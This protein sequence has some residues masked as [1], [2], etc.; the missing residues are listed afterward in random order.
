MCSQTNFRP[1]DSEA[2]DASRIPRL[3]ERLGIAAIESK[4]LAK[5]EARRKWSSSKNLNQC[6][7]LH[8][9]LW[10]NLFQDW[11]GGRDE[12]AER[13]EVLVKPC[14]EQSG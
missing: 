12:F 8:T 5:K 14:G 11:N 4:E 3:D 10:R 2:L 9:E 6:T 7:G 1:V 13:A